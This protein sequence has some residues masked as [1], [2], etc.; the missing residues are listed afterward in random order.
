[1]LGDLYP[2]FALLMDLQ[3]PPSN[4]GALMVRTGFRGVRKQKSGAKEAGDAS[5]LKF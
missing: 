4:V 5:K 1:M 2:H 3:V